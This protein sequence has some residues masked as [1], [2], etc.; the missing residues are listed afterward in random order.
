MAN[1]VCIHISTPDTYGEFWEPFVD[2]FYP[3][4]HCGCGPVYNTHLFDTA[5]ALDLNENKDDIENEQNDHQH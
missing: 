5:V 2:S 4:V 1:I 3:E